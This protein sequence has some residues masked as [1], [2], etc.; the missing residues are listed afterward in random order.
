MGDILLK[1]DG[2]MALSYS[3]TKDTENTIE[4]LGSLQE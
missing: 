1:L 3:N 4:M 2:D